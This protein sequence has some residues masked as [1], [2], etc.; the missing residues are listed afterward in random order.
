MPAVDIDRL[1]TRVDSA[2][3]DI[4][5]L[6]GSEQ[7]AFRKFDNLYAHNDVVDAKVEKIFA[8]ISSM[9]GGIRV[10]TLMIPVATA[11]GI[12]IIGFM[13]SHFVK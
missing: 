8:A 3:K 1:N 5:R 7:S 11:T 6:Q 9:E 2:E 12:A 10:I 13:L 4:I